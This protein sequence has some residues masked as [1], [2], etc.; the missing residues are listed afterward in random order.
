MRPAMLENR[1]GPGP[2]EA[3]SGP[4]IEK[5]TLTLS[6]LTGNKASAPADFFKRPCEPSGRD[7]NRSGD[8]QVVKQGQ[9]ASITAE[10]Q[11][12]HLAGGHAHRAGARA[13]G[14]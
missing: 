4:L 7:R 12:A 6:R 10:D 9:P 5:A 3:N 1:A 2:G 14:L 13:C 11:K 8:T